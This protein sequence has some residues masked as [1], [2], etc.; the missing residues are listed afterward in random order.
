MTCKN[1]GKEIKDGEK[2]CSECGKAI[3]KAEKNPEQI[4][5][6]LS[7][8]FCTSNTSSVKSIK[9][10][11]II[12]SVLV[13]AAIILLFIVFK[14]IS[15]PSTVS[16]NTN[17]LTNYT[18][19]EEDNFGN[20]ETVTAIEQE[21]TKL[22]L[23]DIEFIYPDEV[24]AAYTTYK[25]I[26]YSIIPDQDD[27]QLMIEISCVSPYDENTVYNNSSKDIFFYDAEGNYLGSDTIFLPFEYEGKSMEKGD[28]KKITTPLFLSVNNIDINDIA[29]IE[30]QN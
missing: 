3:E 1:C 8:N 5:D 19:I 23:S 14:N 30:I 7:K 28:T 29:R 6:S 13:C 22:P 9:N 27:A 15:T 10:K 2:F 11:K 18:T 26:D 17:N 4:T 21:T 16:N 12:A 25:I 24:T 20:K